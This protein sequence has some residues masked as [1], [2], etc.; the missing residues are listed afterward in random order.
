MRVAVGTLPLLERACESRR[1]RVGDVVVAGNR[2]ERKLQPAEDLGRAPHLVRPPAVSH[3]ARRDEEL[4]SE[5]GAELAYREE[6]REILSPTDVRVGKV[7]NPRGHRRGRLYA[8]PCARFA[9]RGRVVPRRSGSLDSQ[10]GERVARAIRRCLSRPSSGR[11]GSKAAPRGASLG[12]GRGGHRP[13]APPVPVAEVDRRRCLRARHLRSRVHGRRP[14]LRPL[15]HGE[16]LSRALAGVGLQPD[17][18]T[19]RRKAPR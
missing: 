13:L 15:A 16:A 14:H 6:R 5:P 2:E 1:E 10:R 7:Q 9:R 17:A 4:R 18:K 3:V 19:S 8:V 11:R 12:R